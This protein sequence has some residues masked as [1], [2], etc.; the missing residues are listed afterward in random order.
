MVRD[1]NEP[2]SRGGHPAVSAESD[3]NILAWITS[4]AEK[5]A[6]VTH[7]DIKNYC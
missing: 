2:K 5:I 1:L 6:A 4:Q 7:M 3:G